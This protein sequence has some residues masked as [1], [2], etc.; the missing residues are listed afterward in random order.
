MAKSKLSDLIQWLKEKKPASSDPFDD[1]FFDM[2][3]HLRKLQEE[4]EVIGSSFEDMEF[5]RRKESEARSTY[6]A[7]RWRYCE[8]R[9]GEGDDE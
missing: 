1:N 8:N 9:A 4:N 6:E 3:E 2:E 5:H 7:R